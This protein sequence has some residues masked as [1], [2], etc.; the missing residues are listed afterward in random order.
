V[1][2]AARPSSWSG[3][4]HFIPFRGVSIWPSGEWETP[5]G[6]VA[7]D[8]ELATRH[9]GE[10]RTSATGLTAHGREHSLEMQMPFIAHLLPGIPIVPLVMGYQ[11]RDAAFALGDAIA[12]A[13]AGRAAMGATR[14]TS[15]SSPAA[16]S[17]TTKMRGR[18]RGWIR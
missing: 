9:R 10:S 3:P 5:F 2:P 6:R 13:V 12:R 15:C 4:S 1:R 7:V 18:Q 8:E 17:R 16:T 11:T 14:E